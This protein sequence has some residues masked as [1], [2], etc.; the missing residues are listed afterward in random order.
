MNPVELLALVM[1]PSPN[2]ILELETTKVLLQP[3]LWHMQLSV[4]ETMKPLV[5]NNGERINDRRCLS[6]TQLSKV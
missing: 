6:F 1:T 5:V 2:G 4:G 3:Q